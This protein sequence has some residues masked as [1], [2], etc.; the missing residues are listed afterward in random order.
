MVFTIHTACDIKKIVIPGKLPL[1]DI[2]AAQKIRKRKSKKLAEHAA[3]PSALIIFDIAGPFP[4]SYRGY[5][6]F[7]GLINNWSRKTWTL[8]KYR[9]DEIFVLC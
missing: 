1:C 9:K 2:C 3:E 5:R 4:A 8:L 6:Y 7:G